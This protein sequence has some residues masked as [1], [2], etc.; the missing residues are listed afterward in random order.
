MLKQDSTGQTFKQKDHH[1]KAKVKKNFGLMTDELGGKIMRKFAGLRTKKYS[2][3]K[4][5][6][7]EDEK[8]KNMKKCVIK[9]KLKFQDYKDCLE[10]AQIERKIN[11]LN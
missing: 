10:A 8:A 3:L 1:L 7:D 4:E 2:Y 9:R 11:R 5:N 6:N